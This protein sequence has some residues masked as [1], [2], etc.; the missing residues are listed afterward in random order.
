MRWRKETEVRG[1]EQDQLGTSPER[2]A[3]H[4]Y[5]EQHSSVYLSISPPLG[6]D[7]I[8]EEHKELCFIRDG[9]E[10]GAAALGRLILAV[11][12]HR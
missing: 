4:A 1:R 10:K 5:P 2:R 11:W 6:G 8:R 9:E 3:A 12:A 7:C